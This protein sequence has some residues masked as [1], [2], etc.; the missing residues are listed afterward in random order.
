MSEKITSQS[1]FWDFAAPNVILL[2][3][4]LEDD[5]DYLLPHAIAQARACSATIALAHAVPAAE[6]TGLD[7]TALLPA[8]AAAIEQEAKRR[9]D[10]IAAILRSMGI[11]CHILLRHGLPAEV[12]PE[13]AREIGATR[14]IIGTHGRRHLKKLLLGSVA[15]EILHKVDVPICTIGPNAPAPSPNGVPCRILHPVSLSA[16]YEHSARV[17]LEIAQFYQAEITLLHVLDRNMQPEA[18]VEVLVRWTRAALERLI[19]DEA[20]LWTSSSVEV[21]KG[22]VVTQILNAA[23]E[24]NA[25]LIVLGVSDDVSFWPIREDSTAYEIILHARC[26]VLTVRRS[27]TTQCLREHYDDGGSVPVGHS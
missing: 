17:A 24:M 6:V 27:A 8:E 22:A 21:E 15:N 18:D 20:P 9:L 13:M 25:D 26:P 2:T 4:D 3:T 7:T 5:I 16:G 19:P 14:L 12:I 23:D 11:S 10:N 1:E